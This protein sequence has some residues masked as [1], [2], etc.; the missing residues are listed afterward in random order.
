MSGRRPVDRLCA[1]KAVGGRQSKWIY[2]GRG[3]AK[4]L[5][6]HFASV[7]S[8]LHCRAYRRVSREVN[9]QVR[10]LCQETAPF[11]IS[12]RSVKRALSKLRT[13]K[14]PGVDNLAPEFLVH[15]P[16]HAHGH[17]RHLLQCILDTGYI[18]AS[19]NKT[20]LVPIYKNGKPAWQA[21]SY[22]FIGLQPSCLK[23]LEIILMEH[24]QLLV[25][26]HPQQFGF[27]AGR[28]ASQYLSTM[29]SFIADTLSSTRLRQA[30]RSETNKGKVLAVTVD[31]EA[32]F[33]HVDPHKIL[34]ILQAHGVHPHVLRF[35]LRLFRAR[36][37]K[38]VT[39]SGCSNWRGQVLGG[40]QGSISAPT[41]WVALIATLLADLGELPS[42][43]QL[44]YA[45]DLTVLIHGYELQAMES[46]AKRALDC[47][48]AWSE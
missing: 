31:F 19:W 10:Q 48:V 5:L 41:F 44:A 4:A 32:A 38:V 36:M 21:K 40:T 13:G 20:L 43:I 14:T 9:A 33:D 34:C 27:T 3:R 23:V 26:P 11:T 6:R 1:L 24:V 39:G 37:V 25:P 35:Y 47:I 7:T 16:H 15:L 30:G 2:T 18:P 46:L 42:C 22:R 29:S 17:L 12:M 28:S 8:P 45:D